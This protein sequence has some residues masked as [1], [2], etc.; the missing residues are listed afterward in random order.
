MALISLDEDS[1]D[2]DIY[3]GIFADIVDTQTVGECRMECGNMNAEIH[4][5][6]M[7]FASTTNCKIHLESFGVCIS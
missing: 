3:I 1:L 2:E 6:A 5:L 7:N 4:F